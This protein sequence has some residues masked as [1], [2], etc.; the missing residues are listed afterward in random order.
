[1]NR[2]QN[3]T[4]AMWAAVATALL[5]IVALFFAFRGERTSNVINLPPDPNEFSEVNP[6]PEEI[7]PDD[8]LSLE[9]VEITRSNAALLIADLTRPTEYTC[10]GRTVKFSGDEKLEFRYR[11]NA[12]GDYQ[13]ISRFY[14]DVWHDEAVYTP[15]KVC[16]Y[17][18]GQI[19]PVERG[20]FTPDAACSMPTYEDILELNQESITDAKYLD[21]NDVS[22]IWVGVRVGATEIEYWVD[23][24][25]G[26][27]INA[28]AWQGG[29][30]AW[31]FELSDTTLE[32]PADD[33]FLLPSGAYVWE[34]Y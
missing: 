21:Y 11:L 19:V 24:E 4:L 27:L 2:R 8:A 6:P 28:V 18:D 22:C 32:R 10:V 9:R 15:E 16:M 34:L 17:S 23:L 14:D 13:K 31:E 7:T 20:D 29:E 25:N 1:M 5:V 26:L 30:V 12:L 33:A 3:A